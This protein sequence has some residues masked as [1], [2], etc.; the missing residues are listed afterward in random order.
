MLRLAKVLRLPFVRSAGGRS[1]RREAPD[2]LT[3]FVPTATGS[4]RKA[5]RSRV[6]ATAS[7]DRISRAP[8]HP[9]AS[10]IVRGGN[11]R[12]LA[13]PFPLHFCLAKPLR[14]ASCAAVR[15][16]PSW[17]AYGARVTC[18][19]LARLRFLTGGRGQSAFKVFP[20]RIKAESRGLSGSRMMIFGG[21]REEG[22]S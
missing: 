18:R 15:P 20:N 10:G 4:P 9:S 13:P 2:K 16:R 8:W 12:F 22:N 19:A 7:L 1:N 17:G 5:A 21:G 6:Q 3:P 11:P 14:R